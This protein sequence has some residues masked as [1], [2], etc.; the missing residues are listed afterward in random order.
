MGRT[1]RWEQKS[2]QSLD[3]KVFTYVSDWTE[4]NEEAQRLLLSQALFK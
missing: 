2:V 1:Y 3:L 4:S